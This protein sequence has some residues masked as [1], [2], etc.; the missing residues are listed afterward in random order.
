MYACY[1]ASVIILFSFIVTS[2][3]FNGNILDFFYIN[4]KVLK[5]VYSILIFKSWKYI[6]Q[7]YLYDIYV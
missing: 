3:M 7:E 4:Y 5:I 6:E 1:Q 2:V